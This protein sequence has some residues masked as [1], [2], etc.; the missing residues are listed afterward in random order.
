LLVV[1]VDALGTGHLFAVHAE[2]EL[3]RQQHHHGLRHLVAY[4]HPGPRLPPRPD[5]CR[6]RRHPCFLSRS[7]VFSRAM[8][9]RRMRI[10]DEFSI[11]SVAERNRRRNRASSSRANSV[12]RSG[13]SISRAFSASTGLVSASVSAMAH[14]S[15]RVTKRVL[16]GS[17]ADASASDLRANSSVMPSSSMSIRPG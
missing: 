15:S 12:S 13:V 7:T 8:L 10:C 4:Y 1:H 16:I 14:L 17:L 11:A 9:R 3:A 2:T 6:F 5:L